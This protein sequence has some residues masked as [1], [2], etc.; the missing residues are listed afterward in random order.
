MNLLFFYMCGTV[1][2][3]TTLRILSHP[4]PMYAV[5]YLLCLILSIAGVF[6]SI[7]AYLAGILEVIIYAG[8]IMVL[9]IF[10]LMTLNIDNSIEYKTFMNSSWGIV[11]IILLLLIFSIIISLSI[12]NKIPDFCILNGYVINAKQVGMLLFGPY[13]LLIEFVSLLMLAGLIVAFHI[14]CNKVR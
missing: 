11:G 5:L 14:G 1:S 6:F 3:L 2:I 12:P 4:N 9:F 8:A 10:I 7:G 13:L